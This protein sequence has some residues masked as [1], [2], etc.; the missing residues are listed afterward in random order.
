VVSDKAVSPG[1][2]VQPGSPLYTVVDP[3]RMRLVA[4]VPAEGIANLRVGTPVEFV[5]AG[6]PGQRFTGAVQR[7]NPVA[8]PATRQ[9]EIH[10]AL[11]N[12]EGRLLS[13][14]F[15]EGR[16]ATAA[17]EALAV[18]AAA[19]D[20]SLGEPALLRLAGGRVERVPVRLGITDEDAEKV[21]VL[22]GVAAGD[23]VLVGT[24]RSITPGAK[25]IVQSGAA[26][27]PIDSTPEGS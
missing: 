10:V 1:D 25:V 12:A 18:P 26:A 9:V 24:A 3:A 23:L 6:L 17:K 7:V 14:L 19:I 16:V 11:P 13:G 15:A 20:R 22:S 8:D 2:T 21:E 4:H 27:A 5:V